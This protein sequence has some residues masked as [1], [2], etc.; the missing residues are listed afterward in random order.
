MA[1]SRILVHTIACFAAIGGFLFGYDIGVISGVLTMEYFKAR[2]PSSPAVTGAIVSSLMAGCSVGA[3]FSAFIADRIGRRVSIAFCSMLF[4]I[5][6]AL[7]GNAESFS[8]LYAGRVVAGLAVGALS[9]IVPLYQSEIA[10]KDLRG[11]LISLQQLAITV[12]I[13]VSFWINY[14]TQKLNDDRQWQIPLLIQCVP[15]AILT[16][17]TMFLPYSPRWLV[18]QNRD[19]DALRVLNILRDTKEEAR[20]EYEEIKQNVQFEQT[21]ASKGYFELFSKGPENIRKR[22]L[23]GIAIQVFSQLTGINSI[24]YYAPE[25]FRNIGLQET[26]ASLL[27]TAINGIINVVFT[28]PAVLFVD[29]WGR[30]ATLITGAVMMCLSMSIMGLLLGVYSKLEY[31]PQEDRNIVITTV[32]SVKLTILISL[33]FFVANFAY[34]WGPGCWIYPAEIYPLRIRAK[35]NSITTASNWITNWVIGQMVPIILNATTWGLYAVFALSCAVMGLVVHFFVPET[36]GKSLEEMD[37]VFG[38][39]LKNN[40]L[41]LHHPKTAAATLQQVQHNLA[42]FYLRDVLD[43]MVRDGSDLEQGGDPLRAERRMR[44]AKL[45]KKPQ[46]VQNLRSTLSDMY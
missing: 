33:Y 40:E 28:I 37:L 7:Q 32:T 36:K 27:A 6:S 24:M 22:L 1:L 5:G 26:S 38:G 11:R 14:F 30:R 17:G 45:K 8:Q 18:D 2:F 19:I 13:A 31:S 39:E 29:R 34:S 3:L 20:L 43:R 41:G 12:G 15:A 35:A 9:M 4:I 25:M 44:R 42:P 10:P 21:F 23:V 16:V 46:P